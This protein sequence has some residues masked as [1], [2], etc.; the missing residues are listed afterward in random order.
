MRSLLTLLALVVIFQHLLAQ[1]FRKD[2]PKSFQVFVTN[3]AFERTDP[4]LVKI[5]SKDLSKIKDFNP[6]A[7]IVTLNGTEIP[8]QYIYTAQDNGIAFIV[9]KL[10]A[11]EKLVFEVNYNP[12]GEIKRDYK[13]RTQAEL[14][15]KKGGEWKNREY[16]GGKFE[17]TTYLRVPKEHKDHSWFIRYEGPGWESDLV[18]YRFYLD[19]RNA[20]DV[21]GKL[22]PDM[23]LQKVGLDGFD[24]YHEMQPWGMDVMKVG[25]SLGIGS[26][27]SLSNGMAARVEKTDSVDCQIEENGPVY[28]AIKTRYF[29]WKVDGRSTNLESFMSIYSGSRVTQQKL[30]FSKPLKNVCTGIVKDKNAI[31]MKSQGDKS[32]FGYLATY[33][34]QSLNNDGLGLV[35]FFNSRIVIEEKVRSNKHINHGDACP[36]HHRYNKGYTVSLDD[37]CAA[38]F[39]HHN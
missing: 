18:G 10:A 9:D 29:G 39:R 23:V 26:I 5:S 22:T 4:T 28:S 25:K 1:D 27:G 6:K 31:V 38:I 33:G 35:V 20:T 21:F 37:L 8:S 30:T 7:F 11:D 13:K 15:Y 36:I 17:N 34:K 32:S 19:Q 24:S 16:I 2:F 14:S 12:S 3:T